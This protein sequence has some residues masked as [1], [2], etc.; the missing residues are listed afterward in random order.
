MSRF[1]L[2]S[3][4][5]QLG[6]LFR[7][8]AVS[9]L[10]EG[11]VFILKHRRWPNF[12]KT[13]YFNDLLFRMRASESD[14]VFRS[15]TA[16]KEFS[17]IFI[18]GV[19]GEDLSVPTIAVLRS[20]AEIDRYVFP[21]RC[22]IKPTHMSGELLFHETGAVSEE[23]RVQMRHWLK[24]NFGDMTGERHYLHLEPKVIVEP[25][26]RLNGDFS[27]DFRFHMYKGQLTTFAIGI[28]DNARK[29]GP[30]LQLTPD[31]ELFRGEALLGGRDETRPPVET[32][33]LKPDCLPRMLEIARQV[34]RHVDYVRVDFFTDG[35]DQ[36]YV[37]E[38]SHIIAGVRE[39]FKPV[40]LERVFTTPP[41]VREELA[42]S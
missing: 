4:Y 17:K 12:D 28:R 5:P 14:L 25:W 27:H 15:F 16:D 9:N 7:P 31:W 6:V 24:M 29:Q 21:D 39:V 10:Y 13:G 1:R 32:E 11:L 37:G 42:G 30:R 23:K 19:T 26:L 18:R 33:S 35:R 40:E 36:I 22:V 34:S 41:R 38:I 20:E 2:V 3:A 8:W